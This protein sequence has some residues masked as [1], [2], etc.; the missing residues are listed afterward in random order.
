MLCA[1]VL[2]LSLNLFADLEG[3]SGSLTQPLYF[4]FVSYIA[5]KVC[6]FGRGLGG[7]RKGGCGC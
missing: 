2:V 4:N 7:G 6:V 1:C 3:A 5:W